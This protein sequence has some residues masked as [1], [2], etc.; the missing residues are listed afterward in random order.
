MQYISFLGYCNS[1][2][3]AAKLLD[4][5]LFFIAKKYRCLL[6]LVPV[7]WGVL[8]MSRFVEIITG[9]DKYWLNLYP[10]GLYF[11]SLYAMYLIG[12]L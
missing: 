11:L 6:G 10:T 3:C 4:L 7:A 12:E 5:F 2:L 1:T 8:A 9:G